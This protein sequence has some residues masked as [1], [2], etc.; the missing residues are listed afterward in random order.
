MK[1]T[2]RTRSERCMAR[3][4][5][6]A[7]TLIELLVVISIIALLISILLPQ[8]AA[9]RRIARR[10]YCNTNIRSTLQAMQN[11]ATSNDDAAAGSPNT[12]GVYLKV[13][14]LRSPGS[15]STFSFPG[16]ATSPWDFMGPL[17]RENGME[18]VM[19]ESL[20][21]RYDIIRRIKSFQCAENNILAGPYSSL[22]ASQFS[23]GPMIAMNTCRTFMYLGDA[24]RITV[25]QSEPLPPLVSVANTPQFDVLPSGWD[26]NIPKN[27]TPR[28]SMVGD[29]SIKCYVA[30]GSRYSTVNIQPDYDIGLASSYGSAFSDSGPYS[31]FSRSWDRSAAS[32]NVFAGQACTS[33]GWVDARIYGYRHSTA[34]TPGCSAP[35][36]AYMGNFGFFDGHADSIG[37]LNSSNPA[38]WIPARSTLDVNN[39]MQNDAKN[40]FATNLVNGKISIGS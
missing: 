29:A 34:V 39:N 15:I 20:P 18:D 33:P 14:A 1:L 25:P 23:T 11:Y 35:G 24:T 30:D 19:T 9:A 10:V 6:G 21:R 13:L 40:V 22:P 36:N 37:D 32:G 3:H 27:Y 16:P 28:L 38:M 17:A 7:F 2:P 8:L 5:R 31:V 4:A 26:E 12:S